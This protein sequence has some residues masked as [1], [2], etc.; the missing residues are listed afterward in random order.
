MYQMK[1]VWDN[2]VLLSAFYFCCLDTYLFSSASFPQ[3]WPIF[4][5]IFFF[6]MHGTYFRNILAESYGSVCSSSFVCMSVCLSVCLFSLVALIWP[7]RLTGRKEPII[8]SVYFVSSLL[9]FG[10]VLCVLYFFFFFFSFS[11]FQCLFKCRQYWPYI[12][13]ENVFCKAE[14]V[15]VGQR[16]ALYKSYLSVVVVV[17]CTVYVII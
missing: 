4:L 6:F 13:S 16:I 9:F 1:F 11:F 12:P 17:H 10:V 5:G 7:S 14:W 2:A 3:K 8:I 15:C